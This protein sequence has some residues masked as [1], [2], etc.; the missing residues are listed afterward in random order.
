MALALAFWAVLFLCL[1]ENKPKEKKSNLPSLLHPKDSLIQ[2]LG[3]KEERIITQLG[4]GSICALGPS[5]SREG[6]I[7]FLPSHLYTK[8]IHENH[9]AFFLSMV[10][11]KSNVPT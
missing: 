7:L 1:E 11:S 8:S 9:I 3:T 2:G 5:K 10:L 4:M 6:T